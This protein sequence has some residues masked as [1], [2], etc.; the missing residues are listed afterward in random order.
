MKSHALFERKS[1]TCIY[2]A[3]KALLTFC[4][5]CVSAGLILKDYMGKR[6]MPY[7]MYFKKAVTNNLRNGLIFKRWAI[8]GLN[9]GP[10]D[11]ESVALTN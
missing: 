11:Y 9:Q 3:Y 2:L 10:P 8:L 6:D 1:R 7:T 5:S 4:V